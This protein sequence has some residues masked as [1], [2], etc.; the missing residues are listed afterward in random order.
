MPSS[1]SSTA[2]RPYANIEKRAVRAVDLYFKS[3]PT[4]KS[5]EETLAIRGLLAR[6]L[7]SVYRVK[8]RAPTVRGSSTKSE[9][10]DGHVYLKD[11]TTNI[12][13]FRLLGKALGRED[14]KR[15]AHGLFK[16]ARPAL[17]AAKVRSR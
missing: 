15:W 9:V 5:P 17:Y 4:W 3:N 10:V 11:G 1:S 6:T 14:P 12:E 16:A 13:F 8:G 2:V 7:A